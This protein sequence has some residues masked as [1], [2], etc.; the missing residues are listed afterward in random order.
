[1]W[2][3]PISNAKASYKN[4][5]KPLSYLC[6][7]YR[8]G[9]AVHEIFLESQISI[10][11]VPGYRVP[12]FWTAC[13]FSLSVHQH[14]PILYFTDQDPHHFSW[15][16]SHQS[17]PLREFCVPFLQSIRDLILLGDRSG[18]WNLLLAYSGSRGISAPAKSHQ[19]P[20]EQLPSEWVSHSV[21]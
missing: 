4:S 19:E 10:S 15:H 2:P 6:Q 21:S 12:W 3:H 9:S 5:F 1:M 8:F 20:R 18:L 17:L 7:G 14:F 16:Q 13:P 11:P